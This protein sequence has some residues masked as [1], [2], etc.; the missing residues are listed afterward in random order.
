MKSKSIPTCALCFV[1]AALAAR[2]VFIAHAEEQ[3]MPSTAG[4]S[5]IPWSEIGARAGAEYKGDGLAVARTQSGARLRCAFQ[6]LEGEATT[7]GFWLRSTVTNTANERFRVLAASVG[8]S[9]DGMEALPRT[10]AVSIDSQTVRFMRPR[11]VEEY[12][13]SMDGVRQ[14]F[15]VMQRPVGTEPL[16]VLLAVSGALVEQTPYGAQLLL[17]KSGRRIAYSR[18]RVSDATG[19]E[20]SARMEVAGKSEI[21]N[22][23]SEM[24]LVLLVNDTHAVYPI[25][26]DPTFSD[27]NWISMG[28]LPGA[29]GAVSDAVVDG[30]G[31]L[32]IGG[33][34][35]VVGDVFAT[36]IAKWNGSSWSAL[37]SGISAPAGGP[38]YGGF[39]SAL[40]VSGSDLY[41]GGQF[42]TAGGTPANCIAKWNGTSWSALGSG[43]GGGDP[44]GVFAVAVSGGVLYAGGQ[45]TI[46]GGTP[47]NYIAKWNG[48]TWSALGSGMN[49]RVSA[50][51]VSGSDLYAGGGFTRATNSGGVAVTVNW[52]AKWDGSNWSAL[53]SGMNA[54]V[55]ALAMSGS[56]LYAGGGFT[57]A[58]N[59]GGVAVT[60][61]YIAKWDGSSWSAL[62]SGMNDLVSALA[63]S[64]SDLYAG[65]LVH[66][67]HQQRWRGSQ[68]QFH[69][70]MER[71]QL[72]RPGRR[73]ARP[74]CAS[75][76]RVGQRPVCGGGFHG[77][78]RERGQWDCQMERKQLESARLGNERHCVG[79]GSIGQRPLC[80]GLFLDDQ[81]L[82]GHRQMERQRL[83]RARL[84][85][86]RR[87]PRARGLGQQPLCGRRFHDGRR[88]LG[89]LHCQ[90]ERHQ[91]EPARVGYEQ[92]CVRPG[93][94]RQRPV[95]GRLFHDSR[96]DDGQLHCQMG[97]Q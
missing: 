38:Y 82:L 61:N 17:E 11:V 29:N 76:G 64:G 58:T 54:R 35:T 97:R 10:G 66:K 25:R 81:R 71:E 30:S 18:V 48:S 86:E 6:R 60:A 36:N 52:I 92:L 44:P 20:L 62:G 26:I 42:T 91:L 75:L 1:V 45:F 53:G 8:R 37:D 70:Q 77:G 31:N 93:R 3:P 59:S 55:L 19:K 7:E 47:A 84:G 87:R 21:Q 15:V 9:A 88:E 5:S 24:G 65:G 23:K 90:M 85:D 56:D 40:A 74:S 83:E 72:E 89:Q 32:Y 46:A 73:D 33:D 50:L 78:R 43:M 2:F 96:R 80:G 63:V 34:F 68:S 67:G 14:D 22:P 79:A 94:L 49:F 51:A 57:R 28:G 12:S 39:V 16:E 13:V 4:K 41:V 27:A 95:C 69:H